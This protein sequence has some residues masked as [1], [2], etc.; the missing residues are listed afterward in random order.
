VRERAERGVDVIKVMASGGNVTPGSLPHESQF[1]AEELRAI[2]EEAHRHG[3]PVTAH[4]HGPGS[5]A[6]AVTA[7]ADGIEHATF[8]TADGVDAPENVIRAIVGQ[9]IAIGCTVGLEPGSRATPPPAIARR[10]AGLMAIR[11]RLLES[12]ALLVPGS[13]AGVSPAK[14]HDVLRFAPTDLV[15]AGMSPAEILWAMTSRAA[16]ACGLGHRKG[17]IAAGF[18]ADILAIDGDP[19]QDLAAIRRLR[20]VYAGGVAVTPAPDSQPTPTL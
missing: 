19:L 18:D 17:R 11:R 1:G 15:A 9:R 4:A 16:Q 14:P 10:L 5:I 3:L 13:D 20:A 2:V 6:D 8:I 12:G 7:G